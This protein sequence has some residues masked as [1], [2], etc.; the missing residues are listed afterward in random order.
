L[1]QCAAC[2]KDAGVKDAGV[3]DAGVKD[4]GVKDAGDNTLW[5]NVREDSVFC[6]NCAAEQQGLLQ[7]NSGCRR[8]LSAVSTL[9]AA[10]LHHYSMD[11]KS[12]NEA[13]S[14]TA[15]VLTG[16]IGKRLNSWDW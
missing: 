11:N 10:Q 12:F 8:W 16:A 9:E 6:A 1:E 7:L 2:G 3:K 13:K 4:A 15:A 5:F 14:L